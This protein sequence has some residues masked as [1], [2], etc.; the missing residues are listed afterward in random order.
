[1]AKSSKSRRA[2]ARRAARRQASQKR[3]P[4]GQA[5]KAP[6]RPAVA[7]GEPAEVVSVARRI[8]WWALLAM[9]FLTP[10]AMCN[11]TFLGFR[12]PFTYDQY[13]L[14]KVFLI[15][16]LGLVA[17]G[18]WAWDL[19]RR[20]GKLRR[21]PI[22]W[23]IV[24]F[25]G[26]AALTTATSIHWPSALFGTSGRYEGLLSFVNYAV[27]YFL[28]L[29]FADQPARVRALAR[30]LFFS[31]LIVA[32]YG[33]LQFAGWDPIA[34]GEAPFEANRAFSTYGNPDY[35][36]AFLIF[37]VA[38]AL[39]LALAERR[40]VWRLVY[41]AGFAVDGVALI[42][43]FARG[44]WIGGALSLTLVGVIAWRHGARMR[45]VDWVPAAL[46]AALG[47]GIIWRSLSSPSEVMNFG[48]RLASIFQFGSGSGKTRTEIWQTALTVIEKR[49]VL[50]W[51]AETFRLVFPRYKPIEY[52]RDAGPDLVADNAHDYPLHL[53]AGVGIPGM[54]ML[55]GV[56]VWAAVRSFATVFRRSDDPSRLVLGA[57]WAAAAGYLVQ[58]FFGLS[59]P[60]IAFLL[61]VALG[62]VLTPTARAV[63]V[64]APR[65]GTAAAAIVLVL[66]ALG[67][68]YQGLLV[69]AD[70]AYMVA[71]HSSGP[72]RTEA[73]RRAARL[74]PL[75]GAYRAEVGLAYTDEVR[76]YYAAANEAQQAGRDTSGY[77]NAIRGSFTSAEA[78]FEDTRAFIPDE[79]D[80][81]IWYA[82]LDMLGGEVM[83][84]RYYDEAIRVAREG[85][86]LEPHDP[87]IR[88]L[89]AR[90]LL[91]TGGMD[92]G[93]EELEYCL[94]L[95]P[96]Y[97][98]AALLLAQAYE[99]T[100]RRDEALAVLKTVETLAPGQPGV[101]EEIQ[102]LESE[103][104]QPK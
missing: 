75:N 53:A 78:A 77:A 64:K 23:L 47:A 42:A 103:L 43:A 4:S 96:T 88:A 1:M 104:T 7:A 98:D 10:V 24:A 25:L 82:D 33:V 86:E 21:T 30:S 71:H 87:P 15:R 26:W 40:L 92:E 90:A 73:A 5:A 16:G 45:R 94:Q 3:A 60:G 95:N 28:V 34:W 58:L 54:L 89:L 74:N 52:V 85:I 9:V 72:A 91:I 55:Y 61:W 38:V 83:D 80:Y 20:G 12:Q 57:F 67:V 101:A 84:E 29:Q 41:W 97:A 59:V 69:A 13:D 17:L 44:A 37:P 50:G 27:I 68:G 2:A 56:F 93:I 51:G 31:S 14:I 100:G 102:R 46:S 35:L 49:P 76:D 19:L 63:E 81:Y 36:G 79:F 70:N 18:A 66:C 22:D 48:K 8:A 65:W 32:G 6:A 39:A 99:R 11:L 62:V